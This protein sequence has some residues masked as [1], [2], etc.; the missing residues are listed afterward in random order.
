VKECDNVGLRQSGKYCSTEYKL[1]TQKS[2]GVSCE[3]NFECKINSCLDSKC[4]KEQP[5]KLIYWIIGIVAVLIIIG[6]I[7]YLLRP[8]SE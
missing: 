3:N 4:G 8:K 7:I 6:L 5:S 1:I 2:D